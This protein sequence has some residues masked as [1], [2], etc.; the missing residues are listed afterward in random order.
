MEYPIRRCRGDYDNTC[1]C[2]CQEKTKEFVNLEYVEELE[3][4]NKAL[5]AGYQKIIDR[6][7]QG[8][9]AN[10]ACIKIAREFI[11]EGE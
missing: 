4:E 9:I 3:L 6:C 7:E 5:K 11:K 8:S 1:E 10:A 2:G